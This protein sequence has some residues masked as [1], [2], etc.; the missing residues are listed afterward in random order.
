MCLP[1]LPSIAAQF[2]KRAKQMEAAMN[3]KKTTIRC[4]HQLNDYLT[5]T[6]GIKS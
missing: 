2:F 3:Y 4:D 6:T 1:L 5:P